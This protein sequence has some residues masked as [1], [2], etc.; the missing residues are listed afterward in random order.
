MNKQTLFFG[1][2]LLTFLSFSICPQ[3]S[4][5]PY[6]ADFEFSI[7]QGDGDPAELTALDVATTETDEDVALLTAEGDFVVPTYLLPTQEDMPPAPVVN[8][9]T[10][11]AVV[12]TEVPIVPSVQ[13]SET[14]IVTPP[15]QTPINLG[16]NRL[17]TPVV[18]PTELVETPIPSTTPKKEIARMS[19]TI[20]KKPLLLPLAP[21]AQTTT[22]DSTPLPT[23]ERRV[24]PSALADT[25][26]ANLEQNTGSDFLLPHEIK[27][28]FYKNATAL[29]GQT[30]KWIKA[31]ALQT[32]Q[33]PRLIVEIRM[34]QTNPDIQAKR[35]AVVKNALLGTGLSTHQIRVSYTKRAADSFVIRAVEKTE[36]VDITKNTTTSG[37]T[38]EKR[39]IK[40]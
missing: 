33:D 26:L 39:T 5:R 7:A 27:V 24:V 37:K 25:L 17:V 20:E 9:A 34:S 4:A 38:I 29:S 40:W 19:G 35:L 22:E 28:S 6:P 10:Q 3:V 31:F 12:V 14:V 15:P 13:P 21:I 36:D 11:S 30:L 2:A 8:V 23:K 18:K 32:I 1:S 16:T